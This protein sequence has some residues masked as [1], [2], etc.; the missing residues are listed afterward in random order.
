M[1]KI[2]LIMHEYD[3]DGGFG[4]AVTQEEVLG[5]L[6]TR[7]EA[8]EYVEKYS[9]PRIYGRPYMD[10]YE[11]TLFVRE[12]KLQPLKADVNP[13]THQKDD[14]TYEE[15]YIK[16]LWEDYNKCCNQYDDWYGKDSEDAIQAKKE[17]ETSEPFN[18]L[19]ENKEENV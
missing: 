14:G 19:F 6:P 8:T 4:D 9:E 15:D 13:W 16:K 17:L 5:Y 18:I 7:K 10:L 11:H 2:F 12:M 1:D 3:V